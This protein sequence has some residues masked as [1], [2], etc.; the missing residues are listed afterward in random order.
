MYLR[1]DLLLIRKWIGSQQKRRWEEGE[2]GVIFYLEDPEATIV[3]GPTF[4]SSSI[5]VVSTVCPTKIIC[6][7]WVV[8]SL[9]RLPSINI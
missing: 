8:S 2:E 1:C 6:R 4:L 7:S 5:L 9:P 3:S